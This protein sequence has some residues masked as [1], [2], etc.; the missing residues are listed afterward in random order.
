M[1]NAYKV[2]K[3]QIHKC[4]ELMSHIYGQKYDAPTLTYRMPDLKSEN[5]RIFEMGINI[6]WIEGLEYVKD[7]IEAEFEE[8]VSN[9]T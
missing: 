3:R 5:Q 1:I 6:G 8:E 7:W 4:R 2:V 9:A